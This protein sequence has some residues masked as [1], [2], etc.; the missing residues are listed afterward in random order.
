MVVPAL[1]RRAHIRSRLRAGLEPS[2]IP[3]V[4][5]LLWWLL[6]D[7]WRSHQR[8]HAISFGLIHLAHFLTPAISVF[9][10]IYELCGS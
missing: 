3:H 10:N 1:L 9:V 5:A 8:Q 6:D 7:S 2:K 4:G